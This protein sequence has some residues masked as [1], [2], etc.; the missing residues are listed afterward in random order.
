LA[1]LSRQRSV[2]DLRE[3]MLDEVLPFSPA[4][5]SSS[6]SA[7]PFDKRS[8]VA[9]MCVLK[10]ST[11]LLLLLLSAVVAVAVAA[12]PLLLDIGIPGRIGMVKSDAP[13]HDTDADDE[14]DTVDKGEL[15]PKLADD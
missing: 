15:T 6:N 9:S 7:R 4:N 14:V 3:A 10:L 13:S 5:V 8:L 11:V 2:S 1:P 12:A